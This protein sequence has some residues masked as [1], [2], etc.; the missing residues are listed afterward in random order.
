MF[1]FMD[2]L[3]NRDCV[4]H[5]KNAIGLLTQKSEKNNSKNQSNSQTILFSE[6][7]ELLL[8]LSDNN[9]NHLFGF[10]YMV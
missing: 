9:N 2:I 3:D 5:S 1:N 7:R 10:V 6:G 8:N 4:F